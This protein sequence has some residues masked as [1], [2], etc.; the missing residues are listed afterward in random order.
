[1]AN[2][3]STIL[4]E[5][6]GNGSVCAVCGAILTEH[7]TLPCRDAPCPICNTQ[8]EPSSEAEGRS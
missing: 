5:I 2:A 7:D 8:P 1:M 3:P 4:R 6:V